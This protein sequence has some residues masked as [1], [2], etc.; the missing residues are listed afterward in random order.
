MQS[1]QIVQQILFFEVF[2]IKE[3]N[4]PFILFLLAD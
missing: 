1:F 4:Y 3:A 2:V